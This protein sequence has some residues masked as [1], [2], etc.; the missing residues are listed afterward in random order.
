MATPNNIGPASSE[1]FSYNK[2]ARLAIVCSGFQQLAACRAVSPLPF[3]LPA[4]PPFRAIETAAKCHHAATPLQISTS[5]D[6]RCQE[7]CSTC[8]SCTTY[9]YYL[10][11]PIAIARARPLPAHARIQSCI[12]SGI[13]MLWVICIIDIID[14]QHEL[15]QTR[16]EQ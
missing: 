1:S 13:V 2:P 14:S 3:P 10:P 15:E 7:L 16:D 5:C 12:I 4:P 6:E 8:I 9:T 11:I